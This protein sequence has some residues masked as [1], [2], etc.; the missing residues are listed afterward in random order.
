V[1]NKKQ[2]EEILKREN[3]PE[4]LYSLDGGLWEDRYCLSEIMKGLWEV[5]YCER[6]EKVN[7]KSFLSEEE[8]CEYL[9]N[10]IKKVMKIMG[11]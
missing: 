2:L 9:Y 10:W 8:A 4:D 11:L 5:Y 3:I 1:M 7:E 6:G